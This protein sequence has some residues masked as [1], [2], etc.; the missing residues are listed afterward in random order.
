MIRSAMLILTTAFAAVLATQS[1]AANPVATMTLKG[2]TSFFHDAN[3]RRDVR[4]S[5]DEFIVRMSTLD[6]AGRP[7]SL[8][9]RIRPESLDG[10]AAALEDRLEERG[11]FVVR[12]ET[13]DAV[14]GRDGVAVA[15]PLVY[16]IGSSVPLYPSDR[17]IATFRPEA[18]EVQVRELAAES[19]CDARKCRRGNQRYL[20]TV[21][22][23]RTHDPLSVANAVHARRDLV[24]HAEPDFFIPKVAYTPPVI[25]DPFYHSHQWHLDGD[26]SKGAAANTDINVEVAWN[27]DN[28]PNSE[29]LSTVRVAVL[30]ECV[31]KMHPDLFP[32]WWDGLD[33]D[34]DPP[35]N[36]PSP[37]GGQ[38]HGTSCAGLAVAAANSI[39]VRGV[40]PKCGL[41]GV[42]F[43]GATISE[44]ADGFYFAGDPNNDNDDSDG[45]AVISNSWGYADGTLQPGDVVAS[46]NSVATTGRNGLGVLILFAAANN[47]HTVNGV[48]ALAQ[49][50]TVMAVGGTNSNGFHT[51][52]S[53]VGPEVAIAT[54][55]N[56]RGD[57]GV[58]FSW[59]DITTVDNTGTSGYNGLPDLD[60][61]NA[62]GGTSA[63]TPIAAGALA[64][65]AS[66]D[67]T[68][69]SAQ[70][71]SI[72]QHT[73]VRIDEPFGR[74]DPITSH[75]HRYGYGRADVGA[76]VTA[77]HAGIR[78]PDRIKSIM[79]T[80]TG[81]DIVLTWDTPIADYTGSVLVR[82]STPFSWRPTDGATYNV[83]DVVAPGV[84]VIYTG[85]VGTH[86]DVGASSGG[87][88][89]GVYPRSAANRYGFGAKAHVF[90]N[91]TNLLFDNSE[92]V[93]PGWTHGGIGDEWTR[94]TPTSALAAFSQ[95]VAGSGPLAGTRGVRAINGN[96]CW[97]TDMVFTYDAECDAYLQTPLINLTGVVAPVFLEYW[98][99][100]LLETY[101]DK[102]T[103]EVVDA[104]EQFLGYLDPDTGGDYDWTLRVYDL[105][106]FS[107]QPIKVRFRLKADGAYQRDGWFIDDV[108]IVAAGAGNLPPAASKVIAETAENVAVLVG[109]TASDPNPGTTLQY[110]VQSLPAHGTLTDPNAGA[111]ASVPYTMASNGRFVLYTPMNGY[112]GPDSFTYTATD[113]TL[114]SNTGIVTLTIGTP[115][116]IYQFPLNSDPGWSREGAWAFGQPQGLGGDPVQ[117]FTGPY[118]FGYNLAGAYPD[119]L[120]ARYLTM[121]PF[122]C[123]GLYRVTLKFARWLGVENG[124]Y[125]NAS[126]EVSTDGAIWS[127]V[128]A[129][130]GA[131]LQETAWSQQSYNISQYADNQP[132]VLV[133][134][135]MGPT[136]SNTTFSGW[137]IDDVS[138]WAIGSAPG[139]QPPY[140]AAVSATTAQNQPVNIPL[141]VSDSDM[142]ALDVIITS[143]PPNGT[144]SDPN[145]GAIASVPYTLSS[146]GTVVVYTPNGGFSSPPVDA[147][148]YRAEDGMLSSNVASVQVTVLQPAPFPFTEDF[149][150]GP[151]LPNYWVSNSTIPGHI[152]VTGNNG[153]VG[154]YHV[155][156]DSGDAGTYAS[157]EFTLI[158]NLQ[159]ASNVILQFDWKDF[160]DE[161]HALPA[162]W[163]GSAAGDG[164]AISAD[165]MTWYRIANLYDPAALSG[166]GDGESESVRAANYQTVTIDLDDAAAAAGI[167]Y[168][169]TFRIRFQQYDNNPIPDDGIAI[170]NILLLQGT[171]DPV[172]ATTALPTAA[173]NQPYGPVAM[174]A[175]GGDLPLSWSVLDTYGEESLG[176]SLFTEVGV[177]QNWRGDDVV[178]DYTLPFAFPFWGNSYTAVKVAS[179]GWINFGAYVGSTYNN[180]VA[181]LAANRRIAVLW[182]DLKTNQVGG[183]IFVDTSVS[184][185]VT[186]RWNAVV[187]STGLQATFSATLHSDG[188]IRLNYG[189]GNDSLT[190]TVGVSKGDN[191]NYVVS[192]YNALPSLSNAD[193]LDVERSQ[194]PPGLSMTTAGVISGT[195]GVAGSFKP[196][197]RLSDAS[198]RTDTKKL[199]LTVSVAIF[200]DFDGDFDIDDADLAAFRACYT[201]SSGGPVVAPCTQGDSDADLDVDCADWQAFQ[202]AYLSATAHEPLLSIAEFIDVV[203]AV[204]LAEVD[205]CICDLDDNG[206]V[207]GRDLVLYVVALPDF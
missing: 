164:V 109:M 67:P 192:S 70:I 61:T 184:G 194:L 21:R 146:N 113:G 132:F 92:G 47:D 143:L 96:K 91:A 63:A 189:A 169:N 1:D 17:V 108:R 200:G 19:G 58:R 20:L 66:Q 39:G 155:T 25:N 157:N 183:D 149:E 142:D 130:S 22:N 12:G 123:T 23:T 120:P 161:T 80:P 11:W 30:D 14:R 59:L 121:Q 186:F 182:D 134:W 85:I 86:V 32:N 206:V 117:G 77:A 138:I 18:T 190:A 151:P 141:N 122:N 205:R 175:V 62:F 95:A 118:V 4:V 97:G 111:I 163:N 188:R 129:H 65:I 52:F 64:L 10:A 187:R 102:C 126:I 2:P 185:Q 139:N 207:D 110:V 74:F 79:A 191:V 150:A 34:V 196:I 28:G 27:S 160:G 162:S 72:L 94:G 119:N 37:T 49:L 198:A 172:I 197:F 71:R 51:E 116:S 33:L 103:L 203:L 153:P 13:L 195:P 40:A 124:A 115:V 106:P 69:T 112:Q 5:P 31:E 165:G 87:F 173:L 99:W 54:P 174:A 181:L 45:A 127:T 101:Y 204:N 168:T 125:D 178:F 128:F 43:F 42:K 57:D 135:G 75:S 98:D 36:D 50:S 154:S 114:S 48:S 82:S 105:T 148:L 29:G 136:D 6:R 89:Y 24:V 16:P 44:T 144:L 100:C 179:D 55:T 73:A 38:R 171:G 3:G 15:L 104:N 176:A 53:D 84:Q 202:A 167:G 8:P 152:I 76:A 158:A 170:D 88:F 35:D 133:R 60:Y 147:F 140:A 81:S 193:S 131:D 180:S 90:R 156:M 83:T 26:V 145:A 46:I 9:P 93:D 41:I 199:P 201:G 107:G 7:S 68:M 137:N 177:A 166:D 78:W 56:D 159:G